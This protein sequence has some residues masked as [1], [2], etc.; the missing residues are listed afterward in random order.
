MFCGFL[1]WA[2]FWPNLINSGYNRSWVKIWWRST[3]RPRRLGAGKKKEQETKKHKRHLIM[4][5]DQHINMF[6]ARLANIPSTVATRSRASWTPRTR[7]SL[8]DWPDEM[9]R[10]QVK[11]QSSGDTI[12][13]PRVGWRL[14][15]VWRRLSVCLSSCLSLWL[16]LNISETTWD[17]GC[18]TKKSTMVEPFWVCSTMVYHMVEP[19]PKYHNSTMVQPWFN[20]GWIMVFLVGRLLLEAAGARDVI[21][22]ASGF[23]RP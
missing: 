22:D 12:P 11:T 9:L 21:G 3:K 16:T 6:H 20:H 14:V 8:Y 10:Q 15:H 4:A 5:C 19:Y 18:P 1:G 23:L 17:S 7:V 13:Q 2:N